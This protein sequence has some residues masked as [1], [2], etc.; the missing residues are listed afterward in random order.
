MDHHI[1]LEKL[2]HHNIDGKIYQW[3]SS[4][5]TNR[6][7]AVRVSGQL[8]PFV[9]VKSG[10]PQGSVLGPL[11][12][13]IMM[14]DIDK[15]IVAAYLSSFA[16]DTR[17]WKSIKTPE[18]SQILQDNIHR[19]VSWANRNNMQF[20]GKKFEHACLGRDA[21]ESE[22]FV[23]NNLKI[24]KKSTLRDLGVTISDDLLFNT[25]ISS[26]VSK[27]YKMIGWILR[28][29]KTRQTVVMMTLF[30]SLVIPLVEYC[31]PLWSPQDPQLISMI[32]SVQLR[33]TR[34]LAAFQEH[35][36]EVG[37][38]VCYSNYEHRLKELK[39]YSLQ[40]RRDRY[41]I[42]YIFKIAH[43]YVPNPGIDIT[44]NDRHM[45]ITA[46]PTIPSRNAPA[47]VKKIRHGS[48]F[49]QGCRLFNKLPQFLRKLDTEDISQMKRL[50]NFKAKLNSFLQPIPDTPSAADNSLLYHLEHQATERL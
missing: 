12:F 28:T 1:L 36:E 7:Q 4:F 40:R 3:I 48:I 17:I 49:G 38:A 18:D 21:Q 9:K 41:I 2:L 29:F 45:S 43:G 11:L 30:K 14:F 39:L 23:E 33:F 24:T 37:H 44:L 32:E 22:Y 20:N 6:V 13:I 42:I 47:W 19:T 10:V 5:L 8:S 25:H 34:K 16:D 46:Q 35:N 31:C 50:N 27:A 15:T 26:T